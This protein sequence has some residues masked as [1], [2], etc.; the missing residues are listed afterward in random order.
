MRIIIYNDQKFFENSW[1]VGLIKI[2]ELGEILFTCFLTLLLSLSW[3][4]IFTPLY[5]FVFLGAF[6]SSSSLHTAIHNSNIFGLCPGQEAER[7]GFKEQ[8]NKCVFI[9]KLVQVFCS[10]IFL[11]ICIWKKSKYSISIISYKS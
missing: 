10:S 11:L 6:H 2:V 4:H 1:W 8:S 9:Y 5:S 7:K 3:A